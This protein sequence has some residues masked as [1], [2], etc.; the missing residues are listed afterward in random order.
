MQ[1]PWFTGVDWNAIYEKKIEPPFTPKLKAEWDTKYVAP[2]FTEL[3]PVDSAKEKTEV[4]SASSQSN[5][6]GFS[7][8]GNSVAN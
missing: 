3:V 6:E 5:W 1:H 8:V 7:Y 4:A 2:E